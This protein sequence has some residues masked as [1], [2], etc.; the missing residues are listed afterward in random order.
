MGPKV[1]ID[2]TSR[3]GPNFSY[4]V[5]YSNN[6]NEANMTTT[7]ISF[8]ISDLVECTTYNISIG[9]QNDEGQNTD[10]STPVLVETCKY[11]T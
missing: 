11:Y 2:C 4:I 5:Y 6:G 8:N 3:N 7:D 10:R 9:T 1:N